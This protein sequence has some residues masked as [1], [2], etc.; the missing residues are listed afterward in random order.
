MG[1]RKY[2]KYRV[3]CVLL[4]NL[5]N[6]L[7][8]LYQCSNK[9]LV[10]PSCPIPIP[11]SLEARSYT[12]RRPNSWEDPL[13]RVGSASGPA[14]HT[15]PYIF[16]LPVFCRYSG[17]SWFRLLV[18]AVKSTAIV[19]A[20]ASL[21]CGGKTQQSAPHE[22][23]AHKYIRNNIQRASS[24]RLH[25]THEYTARVASH[26]RSCQ[27]HRA[28]LVLL[29]VTAPAASQAS[30][31]HAPIVPGRHGGKRNTKRR[32]SSTGRRHSAATPDL[33]NCY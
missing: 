2:L 12:R 24:K 25:T 26:S 27:N 29:V 14:M 33:P 32:R 31:N 10:V 16:S 11:F 9:G 17:R 15:Q 5:W 20:T 6:R 7:C 13:P 18:L 19:C 22:D 1:T 8:S 23:T 4:L 28:S 21:R 30:S 3:S